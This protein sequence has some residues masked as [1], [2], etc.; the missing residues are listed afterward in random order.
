M[1]DMQINRLLADMRAL[2]AQAG[3][4]PE[5]GAETQSSGATDFG[6]LLKASIDQVNT[7]QQ[8]AGTLAENFES[9]AP[10]ADLGEVMVALQ[11]ADISFKAMT[12]VRNRLV[13]A[14]QEIMN[15]PL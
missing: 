15:M 2:A 4:Q 13:N 9:G 14:Y 5:A 3:V 7:M 11:K 8:N 12:E 6:A 1:S 10:G